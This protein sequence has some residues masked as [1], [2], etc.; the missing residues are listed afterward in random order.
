MRPF[1]LSVHEEKARPSEWRVA[2]A[3][4]EEAVYGSYS[5]AGK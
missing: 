2:G 4:S 3:C 5:E 1:A